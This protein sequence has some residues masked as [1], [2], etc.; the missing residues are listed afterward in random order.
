MIKLINEVVGYAGRMCAKIPNHGIRL[1][2]LIMHVI[3]TR[4]LNNLIQPYLIASLRR[5]EY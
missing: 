1:L 2:V 5:R 4:K 3:M